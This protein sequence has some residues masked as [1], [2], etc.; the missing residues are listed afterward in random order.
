MLHGEVPQVPL[1][2]T[3]RGE[4]SAI[5]MKS[6]AAQVEEEMIEWGKKPGVPKLVNGL[7]DMVNTNNALLDS[8][9]IQLRNS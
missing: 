8:G 3:F 4:I 2:T 6:V 1:P 9:N 5:I 7:K